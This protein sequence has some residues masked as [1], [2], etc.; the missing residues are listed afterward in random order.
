MKELNR[1]AAA[2]CLVFLLTIST[3][4]GIIDYPAPP[5]PPPGPESVRTNGDIPGVSDQAAVDVALNSF[6]LM[7]L[8]F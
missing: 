6:Q 7:L 3:F 5:P 8:V 1:L 2:S 4:A